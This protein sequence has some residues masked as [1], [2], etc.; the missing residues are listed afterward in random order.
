MK[1]PGEMAFTR[2]LCEW[3]LAARILVRWLSADLLVLYP[4]TKAINN[5]CECKPDTCDAPIILH[6]GFHISPAIE[7]ILITLPRP[8]PFCA[9]RPKSCKK[10]AVTVNGAHPFIINLAFHSSGSKLNKADCASSRV[11]R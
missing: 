8:S 6:H 7:L 11:E 10:P 5:K 3:S 9:A 4:K 2:I 1:D